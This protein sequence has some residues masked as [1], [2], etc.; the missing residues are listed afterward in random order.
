MP[1]KVRIPM[2]LRRLTGGNKIVE[3]DGATLRDVIENLERKHPGVRER[4]LD[5]DG[6]VLRFVNIFVNEQDIRTL[7]GL[8]T[9]VP[10]GAEV[11]IIPALAGGIFSEGEGAFPPPSDTSPSPDSAASIMLGMLG[12]GSPVLRM[13]AGHE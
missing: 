13:N 4:V 10:E 1:V 6:Q 7:A 3:V 8:Q 5:S 11:S 9:P 2:P 12:P